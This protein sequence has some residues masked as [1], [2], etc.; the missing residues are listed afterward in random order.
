MTGG[1]DPRA[2]LTGT[3][4]SGVALGSTAVFAAHTV[5]PLIAKDL[6]GSPAL[7]GVPGAC[8]V[9][10]TAI[11]STA[12]ST[13]MARRG[14][15]PGLALG[16]LIG[17]GGAFLAAYATRWGSLPWVFAGMGLIGVG[18]A[19][20][21]L[22]RFAATDVHAPDRRAYVL[23]WVVWASTIGAAIGPLL[24]RSLEGMTER[25][26][27]PPD[28]SGFLVGIGF[29]GA[30]FL[31]SQTLRPDPASLATR[32]EIA[33]E[34][35]PIREYLRSPVVRLAIGALM[36]AQTA[37]I[38]VMAITPVHLDDHG[39]GIGAV[40]AVMSAHIV[41][42]YAL[43]PVMGKVTER[44]GHAPTMLLG[45]VILLAATLSA[46]GFQGSGGVLGISLF[47]LGLGWSVAFVSGS[48]LLTRDLSYAQRA[49]VQ[50]NVDAVVWTISA[51]ASVLSGFALDL[52][53]Y[54]WLCI[55]ASVVALLPARAALRQRAATVTR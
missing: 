29:Y 7:A 34:H 27:F 41:G 45:I 9:L 38:L 50:G 24:L 17:L 46:A 11:G 1:S 12:L 48:S 22:S 37:M 43:S 10:G 5:A 33:I 2:R 44:L 51:A 13:I 8:A 3:V 6:G 39:H 47:L 54:A 16:W 30:A 26:G 4:F 23:G 31:V 40:G 52:V 15:R 20:N 18:H 32:D 21:Q 42:M 25:L 35:V 49:R 28:A 53:G 19:S 55:A 36:S 14:R